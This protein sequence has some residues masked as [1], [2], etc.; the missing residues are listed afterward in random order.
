VSDRYDL[1]HV[2]LAAADTSPA[3]RFLTGEL[4]G[5]I[6]FGS[7]AIGFRPMQVWLGSF[8]GDGMPVELLEPWAVEEND[9]LARFVARHGGGPHHLTFKV[10]DL[11]GALA[12]MSGAGFHPVNIDLSDPEWKEA[13]LM[14]REA[15]G[16]VV[17]L[18]ES[19]GH[20]ETRAELLR[21]VAAHG[22]NMH[23]R[24]WADPPPATGHGTLRRVVL[25][26]PSLPAALGFFAGILQ[27]DVECESETS[28]DLV[29]PRGGRVRL[30]VKSVGHP[31]VDRLEVIGLNEERTVAR[32]RF[33]P[34]AE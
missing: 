20:P 13:F 16:T 4:G 17:Q 23:P 27:G 1:D 30:E 6:L 24:W 29:W 3:L 12:R 32:T 7:Q 8:E 33:T 9:F 28:A 14:P 25:N 31:G 26:T 11:A 5:T 10:P 21:H 2:A 15:H 34:V 18:A 22:P 19:H